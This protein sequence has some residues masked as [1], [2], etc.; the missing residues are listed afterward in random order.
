MDN[1]PEKPSIEPG[2]AARAATGGLPSRVRALAFPAV[3]V[4]L[5]IWAAFT[6][7]QQPELPEFEATGEPLAL[8]ESGTMPGISEPQLEQMLVGQRGRPVVVNIWASWC[9]PCRAEMPVLQ[10]AAQTY[11]SEAVILGVA[12]NDNPDAAKK[13]LDDLGITYPNVFDSS[14]AIQSALDLSTF[15]TTYVFGVDG[16]LRARVNGGVS[17]QRLA[18]LIEDA[19]P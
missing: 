2:S 13:F 15:P 14:G 6:A 11:G 9:A 7:L 5:L 1:D 18:G 10:E 4:A 19:L 8:P 17:E 3:V 12:A 16:K